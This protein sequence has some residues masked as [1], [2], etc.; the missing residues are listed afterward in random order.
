MI[1]VAVWPWS[2]CRAGASWVT[3]NSGCASTAVGGRRVEGVDAVV[4][5]AT[6][7]DDGVEA[8]R[9]AASLRGCG[10]GRAAGG[11]PPPGRRRSGRRRRVS[12]TNRRGGRR[13]SPRRRRQRIATSAVRRR[14]RGRTRRRWRARPGARSRAD[15][16]VQLGVAGADERSGRV[17]RLHRAADEDVVECLDG[18]E[19][20][21]EHAEVGERRRPRPRRRS[22]WLHGQR[23]SPA[24]AEANSVRTNAT[25]SSW[26]SQALTTARNGRRNR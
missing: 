20:G 12:T 4:E 7:L 6:V 23:S 14:S 8:E 5:L 17:D 21:G 13:P 25:T 10:R 9:V 16:D 15:N 3:S 1:R 18:G 2:T 19:Q 26:R 22:G 24:T 11:P